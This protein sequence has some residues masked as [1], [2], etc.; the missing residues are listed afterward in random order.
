MSK[1]KSFKCAGPFAIMNNIF[2]FLEKLIG[3]LMEVVWLQFCEIDRYEKIIHSYD[4][5]R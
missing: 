3:W 1:V 5:K 2:P 4:Q